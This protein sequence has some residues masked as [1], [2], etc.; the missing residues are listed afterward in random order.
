MAATAPRWDA[1]IVGALLVALLAVSLGDVLISST[2]KPGAPQQAPWCPP[3][4][5]PTFQFGFSALAE[6]IGAAM[7]TPIEC[8]HGDNFS[9]NILQ[10]T[11]T[12]VAVYDW[13]TNTPEF[14]S[15]QNH[16]I[17]APNG[18]E[19]WTGSAGPPTPMPTVR[20]PDL[21]HLCLT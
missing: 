18:L 19:H 11:T 20:T 5:V 13:C 21:R 10:A 16:W 15:G 4:E 8:E 9:E 1:A 14:N 6:Q 12:G 3:G 7:G 17:L 2:L